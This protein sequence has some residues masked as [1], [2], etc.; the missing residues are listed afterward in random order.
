MSFGPGAPNVVD[1]TSPYFLTEE[2]DTDE[3][4]E[5]DAD[6]TQDDGHDTHG[7]AG[8]HDTHG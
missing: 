6:E 7:Q 5:V 8:S 3:T 2:V 4:Q 1:R